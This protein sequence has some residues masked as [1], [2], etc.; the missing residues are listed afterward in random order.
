MKK[1]ENFMQEHLK[2]TIGMNTRGSKA[3][4]YQQ[5]EYHPTLNKRESTDSITKYFGN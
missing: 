3:G 2:I 5:E 4:I 1:F